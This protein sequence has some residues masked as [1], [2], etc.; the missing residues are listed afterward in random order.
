M[1]SN[2]RLFEDAQPPE[3]HLQHTWHVLFVCRAGVAAGGRLNSRKYMLL[4]SGTFVLT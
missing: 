4:I 2:K 3:S 1:C